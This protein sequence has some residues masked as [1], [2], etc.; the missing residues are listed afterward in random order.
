MD[1]FFFICL[2]FY[3]MLHFSEPKKKSVYFGM[4]N[5]V[6]EKIWMTVSWTVWLSMAAFLFYAS[7]EN[8]AIQLMLLQLM[9]DFAA[10]IH[11]DVLFALASRRLHSHA[12]DQEILKT[13]IGGVASAHG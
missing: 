2:V 5:L 13:V 10:H 9:I 6:W 12:A 3:K 4:F 7:K 8:A 1:F 11:F